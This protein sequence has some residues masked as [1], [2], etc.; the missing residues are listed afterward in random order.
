MGKT[1]PIPSPNESRESYG[2]RLNNFINKYFNKIPK[3]HKLKK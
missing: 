2:R 3:P 1:I